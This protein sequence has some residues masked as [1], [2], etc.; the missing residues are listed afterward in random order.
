MQAVQACL[1]HAGIVSLFFEACQ[2]LERS[3]S[4][5]GGMVDFVKIESNSCPK[6]SKV[7][8]R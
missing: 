7:T 1:P 8:S 3:P 2:Y 6:N 5:T 4:Q